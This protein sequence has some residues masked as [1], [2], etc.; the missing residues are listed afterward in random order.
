[1]KNLFLRTACVV[2]LCYGL[3]APVTAQ[4]LPQ[5]RPA[6]RTAAPAAATLPPSFIIG[7]SDVLAVSFWRDPRMSADVVVRPDGMISLPLLNDVHAAGSTPEQLAGILAQAAVKFIADP[8]V[9]VIVKEIH[10][11]R[12][13]VLGNVGAPGMV[14]LSGDMNVL[15][16]IA[17]AG[18]LLEYSDKENIVIIRT[19]NGQEKRLKFN[20]NDVLKGKNA[21]QN[22]LL[23]PGD[24][25]VVR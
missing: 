17:V 8:D 3:L 12:V 6:N 13:F 19:E 16:L 18:G 23:Q 11:R 10:S 24:T 25:I 14:S 4:Q 15:Q 21:K 20:Y 5:S 2:A 22:I 1:M 9:T 7:V